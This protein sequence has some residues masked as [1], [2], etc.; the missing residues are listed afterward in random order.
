MSKQTKGNF[1]KFM[2]GKGFMWVLTFCLIGA[3]SSRLGRSGPHP[4]TAS[5]RTTRPSWDRL[6]PACPLFFGV[7]LGFPFAGGSGQAPKRRFQAVGF[8]LFGGYLHPRP[9]LLPN[10]PAAR[11]LG[12]AG[13][14]ARF[15][16]S[17]CQCRAKFPPFSQGELVKDVTLRNGATHDGVDIK[18]DKG[19]ESLSTLLRAASPKWP[20][21]P[22]GPGGWK[23]PTATVPSAGTAVWPRIW[24]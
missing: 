16:L 9:R 15:G 4:S 10:L 5:I 14:I 11:T 24:R 12:A 3:R 20:R 1:S 19:A 7:K 2:A 18:A 6:L 13:T 17:C 23:S 22:C 8:L 21:I